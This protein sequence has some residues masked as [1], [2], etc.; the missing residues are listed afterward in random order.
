M[1][2]SQLS[3]RLASSSYYFLAVLRKTVR[4]VE[5]STHLNH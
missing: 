3:L 1:A 5:L 2:L 4:D